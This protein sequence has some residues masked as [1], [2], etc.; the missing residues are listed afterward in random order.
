[1][2]EEKFVFGV[3]I[4]VVFIAAILFII[5]GQVTVKRLR[6]NKATKDDLGVEFASGWDIINV[7]QALAIPRTWAKKL[8]NSPLSGLHADP[9]LL[10][11]HTNKIDRFLAKSFYYSLIFSG[12]SGVLLF[13]L[14]VLGV[15]GLIFK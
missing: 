7:A 13:F 14:D 12:G 11:K 5:F 1:M 8:K 2:I 15:Y 9:D 3:L 10:Y 6:K 4:L